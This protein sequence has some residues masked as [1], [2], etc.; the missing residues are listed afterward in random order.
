[1]APYIFMLCLTGATGS[2]DCTNQDLTERVASREQCMQLAK[3]YQ[4]D[5]RVRPFCVVA[6]EKR[7]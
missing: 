4:G 1:M 5:K 7:T 3:Q 2:M 6:F